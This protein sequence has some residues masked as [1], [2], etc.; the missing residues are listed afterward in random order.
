MALTKASRSMLNT[1]ISDSSDATALTFSSAEDATFAGHVS[2]ADSKKIKLGASGDLE[3]Y[4]DGTHSYVADEGQGNLIIEG[5]NVRIQANGGAGYAFFTSGGAA[6]LYHNGS[7]KL[8]T[9]NDG[10]DVTGKIDCTTFESTGVATIGGNLTVTG[11]LQV[12]GTTTTINSTTYTVDDKNITLASGAGSS[13]AADGAGIT[14]DGA[15]ATFNYVHSNTS[16]TSS[17]RIIAPFFTTSS[18]SGSDFYSLGTTRSGSGTTTPDVYGNNTLVLGYNASN[19]SVSFNSTGADFAG[20]ITSAGTI[21][22]GDDITAISASSPTVRIKDTTNDCTLLAYAQDANAHIGTYSNHPL[23]IDTNSTAA[24]SIDASQNT[25][26]AG[27]LIV[28]GNTTL[29]NADTDTVTIPGPLAVD[30]DTLYVDVTNDRVGINIGTSPTKALEVSSGGSDVTSIKASYNS[31]NYLEFGHNRINAVSSGGNDTLLLQTAGTTR[32]TI[33]ENGHL[34]IGD[35]DPFSKL[36]VEDTGWSS[37]APYGTVLSVTGNNVNDSNWGHLIVTDSSTANGNGGSIRFGT[38]TADSSN[39]NP[40]AGIQ[41]VAEGTSHGGLALYTRASGGTATSRMTIDSTGEVGIGT[42]NPAYALDIQKGGSAG[43]RIVS[44]GDTGYTQGAIVLQSGTSSTPESRGQGVYMFNEGTDKTWYAGTL[45]GAATSYGIGVVGGSTLQTSAASSG[46]G[47][48]AL[49]IDQSRNVGIGVTPD[50]FSSGYTALQLDGY[51]Y[52]IAHSGG[53]HYITNNAYFNSGWKYGKTGTAQKMELA[54]GRVWLST[55]ASG[56]ADATITWNTGLHVDVSGNVGIGLNN[57]SKKLHV[58]MGGT[59]VTGQTYDAVIIQN[60]DAAGI[61]L[62]DAGDAGGNGGHAG[63]GNDNG[64]LNISAAGVMTFSTALTANEALYG[65]GAGTGGDERMRINDGG[66]VFC[67]EIGSNGDYSMYIGSLNGA[68]TANR[69]VHVQVYMTGS[70]YWIEAIGYDYVAKSMYG[71]A[72][73]Y[74]YN[75][76][77]TYSPYA[78]VVHGDI[79]AQYQTSS[80]IEIAIDTGSTATSNRWGS[81]V[82]RGGTDTISPNTPIEIIQYSWTSSSARVY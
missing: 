74:L 19:K 46:S 55:A 34:G 56:S 47:I 22:S 9:A 1:G 18:N 50:T 11:N 52:N 75:T 61:R 43:L 64:N 44:Q 24:I 20:T 68:G 27:H 30:T 7:I 80:G 37:G 48:P 65:G 57:P 29:G 77:A 14:I 16:W 6:D 38:G 51:A 21:A 59:V 40:F 76:G 10:I 3:I 53:D 78:G 79:A 17:Q 73:G 23:I 36:H 39:L 49:V 2:L 60:S 31:T 26:L 35:T 54:S 13:S 82:L 67:A 8:S 71:R 62:V 4:H 5:N 33:D 45:Y 70:M 12:D 15:S 25:T 66:G 58:S 81:I 63:L 42:D 69:Y 32:A 28:N 72:G 41:G